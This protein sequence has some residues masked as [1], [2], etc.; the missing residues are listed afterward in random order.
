MEYEKEP[1]EKITLLDVLT[2]LGLQDEV[3]YAVGASDFTLRPSSIFACVNNEAN[4]CVS[5]YNKVREGAVQAQRANLQL[6]D[7]WLR[8]HITRHGSGMAIPQDKAELLLR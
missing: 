2:D 6:L 5:H 1:I 8:D 4:L 3:E 7:K